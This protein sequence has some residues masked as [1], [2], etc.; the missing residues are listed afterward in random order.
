MWTK[1]SRLKNWNMDGECLW[2][3]ESKK[4][5]KKQPEDRRIVHRTRRHSGRG[6]CKRKA[7]GRGQMCL[8]SNYQVGPKFLKEVLIRLFNLNQSNIRH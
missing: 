7:Q 1:K 2:I 3:K 8:K 4:V 6:Q 5:Y